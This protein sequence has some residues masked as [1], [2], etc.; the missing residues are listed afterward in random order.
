MVNSIAVN[1]KLVEK[2][3]KEKFEPGNFFKIK[4]QTEYNPAQ[5]IKEKKL[6]IKQI[7]LKILF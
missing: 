6:E 5:A 7:F 3:S 2:A 4:K 1:A